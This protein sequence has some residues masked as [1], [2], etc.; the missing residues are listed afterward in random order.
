MKKYDFDQTVDRIATSSV[1][2]TVQPGDVIPLWVA[3]MDFAVADEII[4]ALHFRASQGAFGY[5]KTPDSYYEAEMLWWKKRH[6]Y[7]I[8]REWIRRVTGIIPALSAIIK[9]FTKDGDSVIIQTPVYNHFHMA[10]ENNGA[11]ILLNELILKDNAYTIDFEQFEALAKR[12]DAKIFILCNPHNP[13]GKCWSKEDMKKLG[14]ICL[15]NNVLVVSDEIHRD[16]VY[17]GYHYTPYISLGSEL[18]RNSITCTAPSKTFN[19]AGLKAAAMIIPDEEKM[20]RVNKAV[21]AHEVGML[22]VFGIAGFSAAYR[23]GENWL[24]QLLA[25]LEE[26]IK[27][28]N[29]YFKRELPNAKVHNLEATYLMWIDISDYYKRVDNLQFDMF[30]KTGV[31][32]NGGSNYSKDAEKFIRINIATSKS[33]LEEGLKRIVKYFI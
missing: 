20:K 24:N 5:P 6:N 30:E 9:A 14:E 4:E 21:D 16:I 27:F 22:N 28:V 2:W 15:K 1:K 25:Y 3:D 26:N 11:H 13:I 19:L 29:E 31:I 23:Y 8:K 7:T 33:I 18:A 10:I 32:I 12:E 17:K